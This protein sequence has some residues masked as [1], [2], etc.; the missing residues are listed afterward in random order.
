MTDLF[1]P[2]EARPPACQACFVSATNIDRI[3]NYYASSGYETDLVRH[4]HEA[5][6]TLLKEGEAPVVVIPGQVL[7]YGHPPRAEDA[8]K[9]GNEWRPERKS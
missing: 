4:G 9:F 8:K 7:I 1:E 3:A 5:I 6:L 2:F